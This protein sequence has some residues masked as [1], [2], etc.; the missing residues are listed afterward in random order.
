MYVLF[1][2]TKLHVYKCTQALKCSGSWTFIAINQWRIKFLLATLGMPSE[3]EGGVQHVVQSR[4]SHSSSS[5]RMQLCHTTIGPTVALCKTCQGH[6]A[7]SSRNFPAAVFTL[8]QLEWMLTHSCRHW[9]TLLLASVGKCHVF[10]CFTDI[11]CVFSR[12]SGSQVQIYCIYS[13]RLIWD[14]LHMHKIAIFVF[15]SKHIFF[16]INTFESLCTVDAYVLFMLMVFGGENTKNK[17]DTCCSE[18][19]IHKFASSPQTSA[20]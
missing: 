11:Q 13:K 5:D 10:V 6:A 14:D 2:C 17:V 1:L 8:Q 4:C 12:T 15:F 20:A 3:C 16:I 19:F 7:D 18:D 9:S